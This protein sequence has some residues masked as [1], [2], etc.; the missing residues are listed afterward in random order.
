MKI[1]IIQAGME[2]FTGD[3]GPVPFE[4]GISSRD[5]TSLEAQRLAGLVQIETVEDQPRN[6]SMAQVIIDSHT[7]PMDAEMTAGET[8][9][10]QDPVKAYTRE[11]LEAIAD[12]DG[13]EGLRPIGNSLHVKSNSIVKLIEAILRAQQPAP[14]DVSQ[15][16]SQ[17][18]FPN[19]PS[20]QEAA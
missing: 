20:Q 3:F 14:R 11:E 13:I 18:E 17:G 15:P 16:T 19:L 10:I 1:R 4:S 9:V 6:P 5:V 2:N 7:T 8:K 12:R